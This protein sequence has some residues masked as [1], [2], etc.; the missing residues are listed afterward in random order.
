MKAWKF[1]QFVNCK[2][3][4][5]H[6]AQVTEKHLLTMNGNKGYRKWG[7]EGTRVGESGLLQVAV[8][9]ALNMAYV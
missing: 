3:D 4:V 5:S 7:P 8:G 2:R 6:Q 9:R 1:F